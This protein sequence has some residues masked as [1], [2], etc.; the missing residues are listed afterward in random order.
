MKITHPTEHDEI[1]KWITLN[2]EKFIES[3]GLN[4]T[5]EKITYDRVFEIYDKTKKVGFFDI[6]LSL[7][8]E[9]D[10]SYDIVLEDGNLIES[11]S[12]V[13]IKVNVQM[14]SALLQLEELKTLINQHMNNRSKFQKKYYFVIAS[15]NE[16]NKL[17]FTH[18]KIIFYKF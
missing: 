10:T 11:N 6:M 17:F 8:K 3:I 18:E 12:K 9:T 13:F 15:Q 14:E 2:P 16:T 1:V 5:Y 7:D 4:D